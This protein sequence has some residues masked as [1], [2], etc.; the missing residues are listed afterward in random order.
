MQSPIVVELVCTISETL[1]ITQKKGE[2]LNEGNLITV[3][4][5]FPYRSNKIMRM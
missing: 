1:R 4:N 3:A 2:E 5:F